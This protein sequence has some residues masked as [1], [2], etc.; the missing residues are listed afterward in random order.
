M[1]NLI[2]IAMIV[3]S[4]IYS[5]FSG[6]APEVSD[7]VFAGAQDC[8]G[9]V[10]KIGAFMVM[11]SGFMNIAD[12]SGLTGR[13]SRLMSPVICRL[14][15]GVNK[16][17]DEEKLIAANITANMLGLSNAAT[18]LGI[19]AMKKLSGKSRMRTAT[20]DMCMLAIINSASLQ[21]VPTTLIALRSQYGSADPTS[22]VVPVWIVSFLTLVFA[23]SLAVICGRKERN[24]SL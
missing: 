12:K 5:F 10:L 16:G 18:P 15:G 7:A 21:L 23:V 9:F 24:M 19:S 8:V 11:W 14:F 6:S 4:V 2:W 17:S 22:I 1:L 3:V 20:N 13:L